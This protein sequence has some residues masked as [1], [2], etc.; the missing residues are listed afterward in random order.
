MGFVYGSA[1]TSVGKY[2][3]HFHWTIILFVKEP[4]AGFS[5]A[6]KTYWWPSPVLWPLVVC[7]I[8]HTFPISILYLIQPDHHEKIVA[9]YLKHFILLFYLSVNVRKYLLWR[10][11]YTLKQFT[12]KFIYN[13]SIKEQDTFNKN[14]KYFCISLIYIWLRPVMYFLHGDLFPVSHCTRCDS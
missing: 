7:C 2:K 4:G 6:L 12:F 9:T 5:C 11:H 1:L 10:T 13:W 8:F 14:Q 3:M